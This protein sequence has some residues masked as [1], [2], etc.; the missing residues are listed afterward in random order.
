MIIFST[1]EL[2]LQQM[3]I[4]T[5]A[6]NETANNTSGKNIHSRFE[7]SSQIC[8]EDEANFQ[9]DRCMR[10]FTVCF[11]CPHVIF[12]Q[13]LDSSGSVANS[14]SSQ[15]LFHLLHAPQQP[16]VDSYGVPLVQHQLQQHYQQQADFFPPP[17]FLKQQVPSEQVPDNLVVIKTD[18]NPD[19][20]AFNYE[21]QYQGSSRQQDVYDESFQEQ[22]GSE[23]VPSVTVFRKS[24]ESTLTSFQEELQT[25]KDFEAKT[26][27]VIEEDA[28]YNNAAANPESDNNQDQENYE[29]NANNENHD[30]DGYSAS[31]YSQADGDNGAIATSY[32]T[33]LPNREAAETLA[34][35][36]AAGSINS[37][38]VHHITNGE[39]EDTAP[40][41][42]DTPIE[43]DYAEEEEESEDPPPQISKPVTFQTPKGNEAQ[44][45]TRLSSEHRQRHPMIPPPQPQEEVKDDQEYVDYSEDLDQQGSEHDKGAKGHTESDNEQQPEEDAELSNTNLQFGARIRPK[46]NK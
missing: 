39:K 33:T 29:E 21:E 20:Q 15:E 14:L 27:S 45:T 40:T 3:N 43:E 22:E 38:L 6:L 2:Y 44:E 31:Y 5:N 41:R 28:Y 7:H 34:T 10:Q 25:Q 12:L 13:I 37:N 1:I 9:M 32:Y 46:R 4:Y 23:N 35:L 11:S 30:E 17:N 8:R 42:G 26:N 18:F 16:L 36:A 24:P 19:Y